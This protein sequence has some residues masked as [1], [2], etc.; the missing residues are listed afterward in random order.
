MHTIQ[1]ESRVRRGSALTHPAAAGQS[2]GQGSETGPRAPE[3][4]GSTHLHDLQSLLY[5]NN[6]PHRIYDGPA[7]I[8]SL[9]L[10]LLHARNRSPAA[11]RLR[12]TVLIRSCDSARVG[13]PPLSTNPMAAAPP[14]CI[15]S[16]SICHD[17]AEDAGAWVSISCGHL[18]HETCLQ[19]WAKIKRSCP[20]C[21]QDI[22]VMVPLFLQRT[23]RAPEAADTLLDAGALRESVS[24]LRS[25]LA[26]ANSAL[27]SARKTIEEAA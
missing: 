18:F 25:Q 19:H 20:C 6:V 23:E 3:P 22:D 16:C 26:D 8:Q 2:W 13:P 27:D 11:S 17:N 5:S 15:A 24:T 21:R 9:N 4:F 14:L 1:G 7:C 12:G 10:H